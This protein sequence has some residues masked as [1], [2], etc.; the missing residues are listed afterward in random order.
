MS[1][2]TAACS[3]RLH[4]TASGNFERP[5]AWPADVEAAICASTA[6][7]TGER[8]AQ[9]FNR[10]RSLVA[11]QSKTS[12]ND[13]NTYCAHCIPPRLSTAFR[14]C[15]T[16]CEPR[17]TSTIRSHRAI[18]P[19]LPPNNS[20]ST[21]ARAHT[22][23]AAAIYRHVVRFPRASADLEACRAP[24]SSSCRASARHRG[25]TSR[26]PTTIANTNQQVPSCEASRV[27]PPR[28]FAQGAP[29]H[30]WRALTGAGVGCGAVSQGAAPGLGPAG[31]WGTPRCSCKHLP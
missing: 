26:H 30:Y 25:F 24:G 13:A 27:C 22:P 14:A 12:S 31:A 3:S 11:D 7:S 29:P 21:V 1:P 9:G 19:V 4:S 16:S 8:R 17:G 20:N 28:A 6:T 23:P 15:I 5:G 10:S 2:R 18:T